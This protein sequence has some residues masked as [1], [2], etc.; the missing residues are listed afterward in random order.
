MESAW[1]D[2]L[3]KKLAEQHGPKKGDSLSKK[4]KQAFH[5]SYLEE[6]TIN[7]AIKDIDLLEKLSPEHPFEIDLY[8]DPNNGESALH[9]K[10]FQYAKPIPLSDILPLLE[11]ID[12]RTIEERPYKI[13]FSNTEN[14]WISDFVVVYAKKTPINVN[15]VNPLLQAIFTEV[16]LGN[17]ENDGFNKLVLDAELSWREISILRAYAKYAHQTGFR[18]NQ[19]YIEDTLSNYANIAY[20]LVSLFKLKHDPKQKSSNQKSI[21]ELENKIS[22][23][24]EAI[25]NLDEDRILRRFFLLGGRP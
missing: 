22:Q 2:Q 24:L 5:A 14:A 7:N 25:T 3:Q 8:E 17:C 6:N 16:L 18:F 10:V 4:Y 13:S 23:N 21:L 19:D 1:Y 15:V 12:L 20:D 11:N 9:L